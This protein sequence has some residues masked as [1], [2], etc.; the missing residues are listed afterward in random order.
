MGDAYREAL[1]AIGY[2][3]PGAPDW[4]MAAFAGADAQWHFP[5]HAVNDITSG[6]VSVDSAHYPHISLGCSETDCIERIAEG[7]NQKIR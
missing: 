1:G 2:N 6:Y 4:L 5:E 3:A 7:K